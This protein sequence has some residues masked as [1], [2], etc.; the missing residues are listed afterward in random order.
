M[1]TE[2][3]AQNLI[4]TL[5]NLKDVYKSSN[6]YKDKIALQ[7]H[8]QLCMK[9]FEYI[10]N[11]KINKYRK[12]NNYDDLK[13]EAY[14]ALIK[15]I[16]TYDQTKGSFFWWCHHYT[17]TKISRKA[18]THTAIRYSLKYAKENPPIRSSIGNIDNVGSNKYKDSKTKE[19]SDMLQYNCTPEKQ[20]EHNEIFEKI[21]KVFTNLNP[22][23]QNVINLAFGF[24]S[25]KSMSIRKICNTLNISKPTCM[26]TLKTALSTLK[27]NIKI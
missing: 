25:G 27:D 9:K 6:A 14:E 21:N 4:T 19:L 3:E 17:N 8:E 11:M 18:N 20:I 5:I 22:I 24:E 10:I 15:S 2:Q 16:E 23:Q 26:K 12:F 1:I 7:K 13:Q